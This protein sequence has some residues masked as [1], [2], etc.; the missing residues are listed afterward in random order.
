MRGYVSL[1]LI[2]AT[3]LCPA[4]FA[5]VPQATTGVRAAAGARAIEDLVLANHILVAQGIIDVRGHVSIRDPADPTH[6]LLARAIA[7]GLV[8]A[9]DIQTF[10]L[11]G[12]QVGGPALEVYTERFIH[13]RIYR[14][15]PDI[16][17]IV[18][19]H[20]RSL[21]VFS[22]SSQPL[23]PVMNSA[24]F[25]G[26]AGV[27]I[28]DN[29][30]SGAGIHDSAAG[31]SLART[32]GS[33]AAVLMHGHGVVVVGP[34]LVSAVGRV[35][36]LDADAQI[37]TQVLAGGGRPAYLSAPADAASAPGSYAREW[38]WWKAQLQRR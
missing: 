38:E 23:R 6:F 35:V 1:G 12:K 30:P 11:D 4:A 33:G 16:G 15:R 2:A 28:H 9:R 27:P 31:D 3:A 25:I 32:L 5:E 17:S 10:D 7:P 34:S 22:D 29:G 26:N 13:A 8:E 18:H 19:A 24:L 20:T 21:I 14:A 36:S 37:E